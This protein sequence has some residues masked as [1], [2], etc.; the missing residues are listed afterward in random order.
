MYT[1]E[2]LKELQALS[3]EDN[4]ALSKLRITEF[5]EHYDGNVVVS[6]SGGKDSTVLLHLVRS[7]YPHVGLI[8]KYLKTYASMFKRNQEWTHCL[9]TTAK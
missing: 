2:K 3:L 7:V 9:L 1:E 4:I 8:T 6:F 5:Y